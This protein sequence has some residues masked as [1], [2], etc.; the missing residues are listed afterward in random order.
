VRTRQ[1]TEAEFKETFGDPMRRVG[2][3]KDPPFDFWPYF[4]AIPSEDFYGHDC[5]EGRVEHISLDPTGRFQHVLVNSEDKNTFM[6]LVLDL[7]AGAVHG[8]RLLDLN[9]E[10]GVAT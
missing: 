10:Y 4:D 3:D 9:K 8:H 2:L 5:A 7:A 1:L 6:V